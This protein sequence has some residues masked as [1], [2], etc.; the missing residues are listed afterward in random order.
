MVSFCY[1]K[2][3][4]LWFMGA[5]I[6]NKFVWVRMARIEMDIILKK[7]GHFFFQFLFVSLTKS[8]KDD[9]GSLF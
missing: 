2:K 9:R 6:S 5:I 7:M 4:L 8:E 3:W 1:V